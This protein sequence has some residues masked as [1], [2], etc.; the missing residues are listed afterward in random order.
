MSC[1]IQL[2]SHL[3]PREGVYPRGRESVEVSFQESGAFL[4]DSNLLEGSFLHGA[5]FDDENVS[6]VPARIFENGELYFAYNF[7]IIGEAK[8]R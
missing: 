4:G 1:K 8:R 2:L 7:H 5:R 6:T 3:K